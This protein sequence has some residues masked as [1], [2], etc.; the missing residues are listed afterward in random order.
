VKALLFLNL[1]MCNCDLSV[2][3]EDTYEEVIVWVL[4][5]LVYLP[6]C[7]FFYF[8]REKI[9]ERFPVL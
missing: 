7:Y 3:V 9:L 5:K 2:V 8:L 4:L 6:I 1:R